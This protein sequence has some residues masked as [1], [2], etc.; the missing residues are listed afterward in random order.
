MSGIRVSTRHGLIVHV[1]GSDDTG[2]SKHGMA[3]APELIEMK[4]NHEMLVMR[5][6]HYQM[7]KLFGFDGHCASKSNRWLAYLKQL[8]ENAMAE[9]LSD[10]YKRV[11]AE[12]AGF[13]PSAHLR[14]EQMFKDAPEL[15][16]I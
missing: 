10:A 7:Q 12:A 4:D 9:A 1:E 14:R 2:F 6:R 3:F 5:P 15:V 8:R 11:D 16:E 13:S